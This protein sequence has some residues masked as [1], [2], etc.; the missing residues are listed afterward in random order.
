MNR[1]AEESYVEPSRK[2]FVTDYPSFQH[3]KK[4]A[5]EGMLA[6]KPISV[7]VHI[8]FCIQRCAYCYYRT[9]TLKGSERPEVDR[10]VDAVCREIE[11]AAKRFH[12]KD[13]PV[14]SIYFGGGTPTLLKEGHLSKYKMELYADTAYSASV[15]K[16][17]LELPS[18]AQELE[19]M[20]Y[21]IEQFEQAQYFPWS[22]FTYT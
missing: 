5:V 2:G 15:R 14:V 12:L 10:Y 7:Y 6:E 17:T 11:I 19:F 21:A 1:K 3:W 18:D 13:M 20:R 4:S 22:S 16:K 8:P 9:I